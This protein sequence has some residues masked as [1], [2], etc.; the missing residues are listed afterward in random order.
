MSTSVNGKEAQSLLFANTQPNRPTSPSHPKLSWWIESK[1][2]SNSNQRAQHALNTPHR[3]NSQKIRASHC[4][5]HYDSTINIFP[6]IH[7]NFPFSLIVFSVF[8]FPSWFTIP[9][10]IFYSVKVGNFFLFKFVSYVLYIHSELTG[11]EF[12]QHDSTSE[13]KN[14]CWIAREVWI[15]DLIYWQKSK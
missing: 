6:L 13:L 7:L 14:P 11:S 15:N 4:N 2:I 12:L 9:Y 10:T 3:K 8:F 5:W 1:Q